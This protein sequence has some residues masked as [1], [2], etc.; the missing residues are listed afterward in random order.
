VH[1]MAAVSAPPATFAPA[2][3]PDVVERTHGGSATRAA[4]R[5]APATSPRTFQVE[6]GDGRVPRPGPVFGLMD[7]GANAHLV[8]AASQAGAQCC[9]QDSFP[10]TAAGQ[11]RNGRTRRLHRIPV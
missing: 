5:Q 9:W 7:T 1:D 11:L 8:P 6:S 3:E 2:G 10:F 4:W